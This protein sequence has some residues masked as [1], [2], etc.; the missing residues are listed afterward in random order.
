MLHFSPGKLYLKIN[1]SE[2]RPSNGI[3][4]CFNQLFKLSN[5]MKSKIKW[6]SEQFK[7][8]FKICYCHYELV[9]P[10]IITLTQLID[11]TLSRWTWYPVLPLQAIWII[12][13][14]WLT[15]TW[16]VAPPPT[17]HKHG[18]CIQGRLSCLILQEEFEDTKVLIRNR[19]SKKNRQHNGQ[20]KK[21]KRKNNNLQN[22]H[23][24]L[25]IE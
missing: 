6:S 8:C 2:I 3:M 11:G 1:T 9:A 21:P 20:K 12:N 13:S 17:V 22:I 14:K 23:I 24:N 19:I 7:N 15:L 25:K 5:K 16:D 18:P 4:M 10:Y